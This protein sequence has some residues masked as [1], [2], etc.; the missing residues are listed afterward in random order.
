MARVAARDP[1]AF[2]ARHAA[3][4]GEE[5]HHQTEQPGPAVVDAGATGRRARRRTPPARPGSPGVVTSSP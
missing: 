1:D 2:L 5:V 3:D 4:D